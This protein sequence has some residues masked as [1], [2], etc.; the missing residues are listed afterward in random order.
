M[1][2]QN[3]E[4]QDGSTLDKIIMGAIIGTAIGSAVG[5]T[6]APKKG[7]ET[8]KIIKENIKQSSGE[9]KEVMNLA[10]ETFS[11]IL[12]LAKII[13][14]GKKKGNKAAAHKSEKFKAIPDE[15]TMDLDHNGVQNPTDEK[16]KT[17]S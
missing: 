3:N 5:M 13:F 14:L 12:N 17:N 2:D 10:G 11:G 6:L 1:S 16:K 8:R 4:K 9:A 15:S 7:T